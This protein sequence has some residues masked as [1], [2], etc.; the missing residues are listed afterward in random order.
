VFPAATGK[1]RLGGEERTMAH[2]ITDAC[3]KDGLCLDACP[4]EC[5]HPKKDED[6]FASVPQMYIDPGE[7]IDCGA[8]ASVCTSQAIFPADELPADKQDAADK[9]AAYYA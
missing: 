5:I 4:T 3:I 8:C 1:I 6:K 9:N 7:C 2:V